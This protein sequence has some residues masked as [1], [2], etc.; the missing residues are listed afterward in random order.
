[1][2]ALVSGTGSSTRIL[3][4]SQ[5]VAATTTTLKDGARRGELDLVADAG[6][7]CEFAD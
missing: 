4:I 2:S 3:C 5:D 7:F 1:M 6:H